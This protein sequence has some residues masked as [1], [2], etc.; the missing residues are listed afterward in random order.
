MK[1]IVKIIDLVVWQRKFQGRMVIQFQAKEVAIIDGKIS[2]IVQK[3][4]TYTGTIEKCFLRI[5]TQ[6]LA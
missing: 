3:N 6:K 5:I 2:A 4:P 1:L